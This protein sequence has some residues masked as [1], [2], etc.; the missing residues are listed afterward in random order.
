MVHSDCL[1]CTADDSEDDLVLLEDSESQ[2]HSTELL[3]QYALTREQQPLTNLDCCVK[4]KSMRN[5][6]M[7]VR[8]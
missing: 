6:D 2:S 1:L 5:S 3:S 7:L 4:D 8:K